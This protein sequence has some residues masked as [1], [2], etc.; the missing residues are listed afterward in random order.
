MRSSLRRSVATEEAGSRSF[1]TELINPEIVHK[2][3]RICFDEGCLSVPDM[4]VEVERYDQVVIR[5]LDRDGEPFELE[6]RGFYAVVFQHELDHLDGVTLVDR[7]SALKRTLYL[8]KL[9]KLR[10]DGAG[11][12]TSPSTTT[13]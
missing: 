7:L 4:T 5:A 10:R 9:K 6:A 3:G 8:K 2:D 12:K 1:L 13:A 11:S